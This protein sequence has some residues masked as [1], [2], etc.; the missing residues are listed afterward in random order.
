MTP[1]E[2]AHIF[3]PHAQLEVTW[4]HVLL[5][6]VDPGQN[7]AVGLVHI[8]QQLFLMIV[9]RNLFAFFVLVPREPFMG[10]IANLIH[11]W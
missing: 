7:I 4:H 8:V 2:Q 10:C 1:G 5:R 3:A 9:L 11:V 6:S